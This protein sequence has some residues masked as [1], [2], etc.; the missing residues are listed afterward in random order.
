MKRGAL[1]GSM[2]LLLPAVL[3]GPLISLVAGKKVRL[4]VLKPN[5]D[6]SYLS[7]L[8]EAG[9]LKPVV[10]GPYPLSELAAAMRRFAAGEHRGKIVLEPT[11]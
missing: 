7:E 5:Q 10:D 4:V 6:L 11:S 1:G 3:L 8:Y 2:P 9:K